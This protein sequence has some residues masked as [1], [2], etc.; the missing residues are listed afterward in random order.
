MENGTLPQIYAATS[1]G[2]IS[3]EHYGP[4][5]FKEIWGS[6]VTAGYHTPESHSVEDAE[7]LW[8]VSQELTGVKF[9]L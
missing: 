6:G 1:P 2:L 7:K 8:N 9:T 4:D 3:G 5:G